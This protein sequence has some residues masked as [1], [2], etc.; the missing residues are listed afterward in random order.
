MTV[1][2]GCNGQVAGTAPELIGER[3]AALALAGKCLTSRLRLVGGRTSPHLKLWFQGVPVSR[4]KLLP[5]KNDTDVERPFHGKK[6][7]G[8]QDGFYRESECRGWDDEN[9]GEQDAQQQ[10]QG[11]PQPCPPSSF[12]GQNLPPR[13]SVPFLCSGTA[14]VAGI[15][16]VP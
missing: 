10:N 8:S 5:D 3:V 12:G 4:E 1:G 13:L 6:G 7:D 2:S 15:L 16:G 9:A 14:D 11:Q